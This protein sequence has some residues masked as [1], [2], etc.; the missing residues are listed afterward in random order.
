M[1]SN[2]KKNKTVEIDQKLFNLE[3]TQGG[4]LKWISLVNGING[5]NASHPCPW[6]PWDKNAPLDL[7]AEWKINDRSHLI[8]SKKLKQKENDGYINKPLIDFIDYE[9][10]IIDPL[11]LFL[12]ITD[13]LFEKFI[14]FLDSLEGKGFDL[15][16]RPLLKRLVEIFE[17]ECGVSNPFYLSKNELQAE[18]RSLNQNERIKFFKALDKKI[19]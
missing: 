6:C 15:R 19:L 4:D 14:G 12:R 10:T 8:N 7:T 11:H 1:N 18:L 17:K 9:K 5:A 16:K 3:F 13:K 2:L